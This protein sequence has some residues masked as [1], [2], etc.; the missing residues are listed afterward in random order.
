VVILVGSFFALLARVV[1][2]LPPLMNQ[3]SRN[4]LWLYVGHLVIL[5]WIRP[6][7]YWDRLGVGG[8]LL[9]VVAMFLLMIAQTKII[10]AK[11]KRGTWKS[12]LSELRMK[13]A[14]KKL[15]NS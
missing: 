13:V 10:E 3:M 8:T 4:T 14:A 15:K 11:G 5:Y 12:Y 6:V 1:K 7:I 2:K 9:C